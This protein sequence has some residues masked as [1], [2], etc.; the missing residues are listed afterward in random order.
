M[1]DTLKNKVGSGRNIINI[2]E[3]TYKRGSLLFI[4]GETSTEMFIIRSGKIRI[5]KQ[6][7]E[8]TVELAVLSTGSVLGELALVDHQPRSATA[9]ILDDAIVTV[10]DEKLY[11]NT[12]KT[13]PSWLSSIV[14]MLVFRLRNTLK[15]AS[16]SIVEKSIGGVIKIILI[17]YKS[18]SFES[19]GEKRIYFQ[20]LKEAITATIGLGEIE[21]ENVFL[22]LIL[23]EMLFIRKD[24]NGKEYVLIV[25]YDVLQLYMN[26][27]RAVYRGVKLPGQDI[28]DSTVDLIQCILDTGIKNGK[29][30]KP[31]VIK[32]NVVQIER[33]LQLQKKEKY[34]N[35]D[36]VDE[37]VESKLIIKE[38]G[39][40]K[41][42][43][44]AYRQFSLIYHEITL[45][46]LLTLK[47]WIAKFKED[48][49]L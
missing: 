6:E 19:E 38:S 29:I 21:T 25:D 11:T 13:I 22:H 30:V 32:V 28:S 12:M 16:D 35:L 3:R 31:G 34:I 42:G 5:L 47:L 18:Y 17:F 2:D 14:Q 23:K 43:I 1:N 46:Q 15:K 39:Q 4:E 20:S 7:G 36:A 48:V 41:S 10:I 45:K 40:V 37:L 26:Y 9:Q 44:Q 24:N 33:E 27:L 8:K 49:I